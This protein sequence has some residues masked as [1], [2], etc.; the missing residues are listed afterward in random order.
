MKNYKVLMVQQ[1]L[2]LF[3]TVSQVT[4]ATAMA[5]VNASKTKNVSHLKSKKPFKAT[6]QVQVNSKLGNLS[7]DVRFDGSAVHG[8]FQ[9]AADGVATV[10]DDKYLDDLLGVRKSFADREITN[11]AR[12]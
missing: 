5:A 4:C 12:H 11:K 1:L 3:T 8:K 7:T 9:S 2:I 10:E 6:S